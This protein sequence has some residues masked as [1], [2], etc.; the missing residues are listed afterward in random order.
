M[1]AV[2]PYIETKYQSALEFISLERKCT[3]DRHSMRNNVL[4][5]NFY[6]LRT[7][8]AKIIF[9]LMHEATSSFFV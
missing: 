2:L 8:K 6:K 4:A 7:F 9:R 5:I 1:N 3:T